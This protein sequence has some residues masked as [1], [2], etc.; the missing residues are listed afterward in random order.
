[1]SSAV[2]SKLLVANDFLVRKFVAKNFAVRKFF[3]KVD[4]WDVDEKF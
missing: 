1:M 3:A 4:G 2:D